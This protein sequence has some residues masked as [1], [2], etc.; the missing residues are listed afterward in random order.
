MTRES[1][2]TSAPAVQPNESHTGGVRNR[3]RFQSRRGFVQNISNRNHQT[4]FEGRE[5]SLMGYIYDS[6][7]ERNPDQYIRTTKEIVNYV[8]RTYTKFT[9]EFTNAVMTLELDDPVT[10]P[11][12]DPTN[13]L[14]FELWKLDIKE[15]RTKI[16][17]YSKFRAG[18]YNV[19]IGQ[20]TESLQDKLKSHQDFLAAYQ[21]G[22]ELLLLIKELTYTFEERRKLS[23]ALCDVK[24][25]FYS[26]KQ[27]KNMSLQ[28]YHELFLAQV[29][30]MEQVGITIEDESLVESIAA[31]NLRKTPNEIDRAAAREQALAIRFIRGT[32]DKYKGY[33]T[34][35]RNSFLEQND[36]YPSTLHQSYN[37]LQRREMEQPSFAH[38]S[39]GIAFATTGSSNEG[40]GFRNRD[41]ITC[42]E[43]GQTGHY[44]N[45]CPSRV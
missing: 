39:D 7:G 25:H 26:F 16:Q 6:T 12:P 30:V 23:D 27:G 22:I 3:N 18:L 36:N 40:N 17:E 4:K 21:D 8:G 2:V 34:H 9:H 43:C 42:F 13:Q 29:E 11:N 19:V 41:P 1:G 37:I 45:R 14:Q 32:N 10:P 38:Q 44:A 24:E 33:L 20:C 28:R 15:H 5:P 31:T 35:L